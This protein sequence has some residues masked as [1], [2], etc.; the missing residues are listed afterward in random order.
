[1]ATRNAILKQAQGLVGL[2]SGA[3]VPKAKTNYVASKSGVLSR[4]SLARHQCY[5]VCG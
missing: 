1:M 2:N 5:C 3:Y 4:R